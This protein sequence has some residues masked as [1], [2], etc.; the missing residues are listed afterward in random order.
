MDRKKGMPFLK[1]RF[2]RH[3][4]GRLGK[5]NGHNAPLP[6]YASTCPRKCLPPMATPG[7]RCPSDL[8]SVSTVLLFR[9]GAWLDLLT[10][11]CSYVARGT[12]YVLMV[13]KGTCLS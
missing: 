12:L 3:H 4:G 5:G 1:V 8:P 13:P 10:M 6:G 2:P 9:S 11:A 7:K